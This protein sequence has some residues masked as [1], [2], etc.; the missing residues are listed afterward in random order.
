LTALV[1][2]CALALAAAP[3]LAAGPEKPVT[4]EPA[5]SITGT[6]AIFEGTL[7]PHSTTKVGGY[8]AFSAPEGLTCAEGPTVGLE[9]FEGEKEGEALAVHAMVGLEPDRKYKFCLVATNELGDATPGNEVTV[10]TPAIAPT[11][12]FETAYPKTSEATLEAYVNA[13]NE[14]VTKCE[15]QYGTD[16]SLATSTTVGCEP[17]TVAGLFGPQGVI[18]PT[19]AVL[20]AGTTYYYRVLAENAQSIKE[21][22]PAEG[23][24]QEFTTAATAHT[25]APSPIGASTATFKGTLTPLN[26]SVAAEYFFYYNLGAEPVCTNE[27][28]TPTESAGN[29][30][31]VAEVSTLV[32]GLQPNQKYTVCLVS[33]NIS[34]ASEEDPATPPVHFTT[35]PAPPEVESESV[36]L[37]VKAH[38]AHFE[39]TVNPNNETTECKIQ[40]GTEPTLKTPT[41]TLCEPASFPAGFGGQPVGLTVGLEP[42]TTY[43]YRVIAENAQSIKEGNPAEGEIKS[44]KTA[45]EP[46]TPEKLEG[47]PTGPITATLKGVLNPNN[48]GEAGTYEFAYRQSPSECRRENPTTHEQENEKASPEPAGTS[49]LNTPEPVETKLTGLLPGRQYTFCL[50]VHNTV[51]ETAVSSPATFTTLPA[52]PE[53]LSESVTN[54]Q[55]T[56]VTLNAQI[57][58]DGATTTYHF[59]YLTA[60]Q[61]EADGKAYGAGTEKTPETALPV[62][63]AATATI[64]GL[65]PGTTYDYSVVATNSQSPGGTPGHDKTFTTNPSPSSTPES[66]PNAQRHAEQPY[67]LT[68][69][70][71][72]AYE[73]VSPLDKNDN[74][75][76]FDDSRAAVS[77]E[78]LTYMSNGSFSGPQAGPGNARYIARRGSGGWSTQNISPPF[79]PYEAVLISP[80]YQLLFTPELSKGLTESEYFPLVAGEPAGFINLYVADI[81]H[82]TYQSATPIKPPTPYKQ[83]NGSSPVVAGVSTDLSHVV[84]RNVGESAGS[85]TQLYEWSA[86]KLSTV[87]VPPAGVMFNGEAQVGPPVDP[88]EIVGNYGD[89]WHAVSENGL[90]VFFTVGEGHS[91]DGAAGQLYVRENSEQEPSQVNGKDECTEPAKACTVE[92]SKSQKINGAGSGGTD[93]ND[94]STSEYPGGITPAFYRDAS[95]D[96][97]R[98]FFSSRAE[99]TN[100]AYTGPADNEPNLYEYDLETGLLTDL[101]VDDETATDGAAVMGLVTAGEDGSYVY[102]VAN[103]VLSTAANSEGAKAKPGDCK[104]E[105]SETLE[106]E[107]TCSLYVEHYNGT[108]WEAPEFIATLAGGDESFAP[109]GDEQDW[110]GYDSGSTHPTHDNGPGQHTARVSA[111]GTTLAFESELSLTG[112]DN[113]QAEP[114]E[115]ERDTSLHRKG[116]GRCYEVY[117][118][119]AEAGKLVCASCDPSG[120]RPSG[121]AQLG[122]QEAEKLTFASVSNYYLPRNLSESGGRLFFQSPDA[123]VSYDSNGKVDVYEWEDEGKG[124]CR[125]AAGCVY[126]ISDVAGDYESDFMDASPNGEDVFIATA[127]QLVPSDTD[128][129]V[130]VYDVKIGGGFP[131]SVAPPVCDNGDSCKPPVSAQPGAFG[132]P[133][134]ATFSGLGNYPP[135]PVATVTPKHKTAAEIKAEKLAKALRTCKKDKRKAKRKACESKARKQ[136]GTAKQAKR[137][138]REQRGN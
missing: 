1:S 38:E 61:F 14:E 22:K 32:T 70:D 127:D 60:A 43:Y 71:C 27:N 125:Q 93:P 59:E 3:A 30:S 135:S 10:E 69:P 31:G 50:I 94:P 99:L 9:E 17:A 13:N 36:V 137:A 120:A 77:G 64:T 103:G 104:T 130:D 133:S 73:M 132:A 46:E 57:E 18:A 51:G 116:T 16:P 138:N 65:A 42:H 21:G 131:V 109:E 5:G 136:F 56:A 108:A 82:G 12:E 106:G 117:L 84:F 123:L 24:I 76:L 41:T 95:A 83:F 40:Y 105:D 72:R 62:T 122:G 11:F 126:P 92:V 54:V 28:A 63:G 110:A 115:C 96:G 19:G 80:F 89:Y 15:F 97:S 23:A 68:L 85:Q 33:T 34:G 4:I 87:N 39:G 53:I 111:D 55:E 112:Y 79:S 101:T 66:C 121:S 58:P 81:E 118:F 6:S 2:L 91:G 37:P 48:A 74:N 102:F 44:F 128:T 86:G 113:E 134:S 98:V 25:E 90:R 29:G 124:T 35:A 100:D 78:A 52:A 8:F 49:G 20:K 75:I 107:H 129:R 47:E 88:Q 7:N 114:G 45:I 67:G 119:D 26:G